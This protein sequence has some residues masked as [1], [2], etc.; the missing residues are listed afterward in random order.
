M[1][2][3][4]H[5]AFVGADN[6]PKWY[7]AKGNESVSSR[8]LT[9]E[10]YERYCNVVGPRGYTFDQALQCGIDTKSGTGMAVP[11]EESYHLWRGFYD[12]M[13]AAKHGFPPGAT[14][15]T[16]LDASKLDMSGL[17]A[18]VDKYRSGRA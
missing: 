18:D 11:D 10:D 14:H 4:P 16:D 15:V 13:I 12:K 5:R 7:R 9:L 2:A 17:P 6:Y 8:V 3:A 1:T